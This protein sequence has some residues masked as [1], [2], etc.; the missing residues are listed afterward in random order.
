MYKNKTLAAVIPCY[1]EETQIK[2][3][4]ETMPEYVGK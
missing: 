3:V 1:N 2:N 4:I